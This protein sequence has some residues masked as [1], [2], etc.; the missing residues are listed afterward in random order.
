MVA[1]EIRA[2]QEHFQINQFGSHF[3][4]ACLRHVGVK[5]Q[6]WHLK[7]PGSLGYQLAYSAKSQDAKCLEG[8][9][10]SYVLIGQV[11]LALKLQCTV[12]LRYPLCRG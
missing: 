4:Y 10:S 1:H 5:N 3:I 9:I 8:Y 11:P 12:C 2:F 6:D 7:G